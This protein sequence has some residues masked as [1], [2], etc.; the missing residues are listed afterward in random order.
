M[1]L[2]IMSFTIGSNLN[3]TSTPEMFWP[4]FAEELCSLSSGHEGKETSKLG[5]P[6]QYSP[7]S[8]FMVPHSFNG[9]KQLVPA[10]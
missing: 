2:V 7:A 1:A 5:L 9:E 6:A 3:G 4:Y 10:D 8:I